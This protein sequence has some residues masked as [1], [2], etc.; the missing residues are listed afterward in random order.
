MITTTLA[1]IAALTVPAADEATIIRQVMEKYFLDNR[2]HPDARQSLFI[3]ET[4]ADGTLDPIT[5]RVPPSTLEQV[6]ELL[7]SMKENNREAIALPELPASVPL[8]DAGE[9][10][11]DGKYDWEKIAHST[12]G[13]EA[14]VEVARPAFTRDGKVAVVRV[15]FRQPQREVQEYYFLKRVGEKW[16][17]ASVTTG[18]TKP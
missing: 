13:V 17:M 5:L 4:M 15:V 2:S 7:E 18:R 8:G 16:Q 1:L 9:L 3:A 6:D 10:R 12:G 14:V 11:V